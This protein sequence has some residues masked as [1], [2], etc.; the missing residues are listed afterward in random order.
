MLA[1]SRSSKSQKISLTSALLF[2]VVVAIV[3]LAG[4]FQKHEPTVPSAATASAGEYLFCLWNVENLF[5]DFNDRRGPEDEEYDDWFANNPEDLQRK[6]DRLTE[7]LLRLNNGGG[8]DILCALE[9]ESKRAAEL[10]ASSLN[11]RL[12]AGFSRYETVV[13]EPVAAGRHIAPAMISRLPLSSRHPPRLPNPR[14]RI[15]VAGVMA[16]GHEL[17]IYATHWTSRRSDA[18]G[19]RRAAYADLVY[20]D[21]NRIFTR[22]PKA[23][24]IVCGDFNDTP[25]DASV[26]VHLRTA[27][28]EAVRNS[29]E[30]RFFNLLEG[31]DANR[32][33][34]HFHHKLVIYDQIC[35]SP[36]LLDEFAWTCDPNTLQVIH[37][38]LRDPESRSLKPWSFGKSDRPLHRRGYSDHFPVVA[39]F[40]V[41]ESSVVP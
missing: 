32:Y 26:R 35:L 23:D 38:G 15:L 37:E 40:R 7:A 14:Q 17:T 3:Y 22:N 29:R 2:F 18:T 28:W 19:E 39:R 21:A 4:W 1:R 5:D 33:G 41:Q 25:D 16:G 31:K 30:L 8:P 12:A 34:T 10:L 27:N 36:G 6:L 24:I 20:G 13:M 9:V 11:R